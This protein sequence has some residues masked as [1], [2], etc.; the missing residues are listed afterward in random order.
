MSW[1]IDADA[2]K[3]TIEEIDWYHVSLQGALVH[4]ANSALHTPL[5]KADDIYN[6]LDAAPTIDAEPV[7][8]GRWEQMKVFKS[9]YVC[10]ECGDL[11]PEEKSNYCPNCGAKMEV[12]Q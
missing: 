11:W 9:E 5:Y 3:D 6:A 4:G 1:L 8:H 2:L 7:K 10:S 12:E